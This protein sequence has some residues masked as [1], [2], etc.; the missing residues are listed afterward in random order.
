MLRPGAT[1]A[2]TLLPDNIAAVA[3]SADST[4]SFGWRIVTHDTNFQDQNWKIVKLR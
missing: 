2:T 1:V 3:A 4:V